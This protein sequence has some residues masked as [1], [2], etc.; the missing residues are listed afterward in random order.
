MSVDGPEVGG[1][2]T[3]T[4]LDA[5]SPISESEYQRSGQRHQVSIRRRK[6]YRSPKWVTALGYALFGVVVIANIYVIV[7]LALGNGWN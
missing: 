4:V 1:T 5:G 3:T 7:E 6:I 2:S